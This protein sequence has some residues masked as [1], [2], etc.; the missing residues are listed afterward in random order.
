MLRCSRL[1]RVSQLDVEKRIGGTSGNA[2]NN[3]SNN[4]NLL[5]RSAFAVLAP[6]LLILGV[7]L[8]SN[9]VDV[10]GDSASGGLT[11]IVRAFACVLAATIFLFFFALDLPVL[12]PR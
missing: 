8:V 2:S 4:R 12:H 3:Q 1:A 10:S 5:A 6:L 11:Y 7:K 9:G